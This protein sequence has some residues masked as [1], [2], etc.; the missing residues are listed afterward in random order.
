[1]CTGIEV[2]FTKW[3]IFFSS[4]QRKLLQLEH[5]KRVERPFDLFFYP[6]PPPPPNPTPPPPPTHTPTP[7]PPPTQPTPPPPTHNHW[8][9]R[10]HEFAKR[11]EKKKKPGT[12]RASGLEV[13]AL[14]ACDV[15]SSAS[16]ALCQWA[17]DT[18]SPQLR[19]PEHKKQPDVICPQ[20][21]G[22]FLHTAESL[23]LLHQLIRADNC[24]THIVIQHTK[25]TIYWHFNL[26][27]TQC[28][29]SN[30]NNNMNVI[31]ID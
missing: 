17:N 22:D 29:S 20:I 14:W 6:P 24:L 1:M 21:Q 28:S 8:H 30:E 5:K 13:C 27:F 26:I 2:C 12:H 3:K 4:P 25:K 9:H 19:D 23:L 10:A 16:L 7:P 31:N 18:L 11:K 15:L